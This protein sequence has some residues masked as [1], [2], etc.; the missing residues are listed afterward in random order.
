MFRMF[1]L[2]GM[3]DI[4]FVLVKGDLKTKQLDTS[5][6]ETWKSHKKTAQSSV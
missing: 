5:M 4:T 1:S 3:A 2:S 6:V